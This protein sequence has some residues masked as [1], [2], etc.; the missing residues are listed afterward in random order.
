MP[1]LAGDTGGVSTVVAA[2]RTGLLVPVGDADAFAAA[3]RRL[4]LDAELRRRMGRAAVDYVRA[5]H[6]LP[7][8]GVALDAVLRGAVSGRAARPGSAPF[9]T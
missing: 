4:L 9:P 7:A 6:D 1:V 3:T 2:G 5:T 8:A